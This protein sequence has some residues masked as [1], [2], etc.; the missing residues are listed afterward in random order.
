MPL[1]KSADW[2][3][4]TI[5]LAMLALLALLAVVGLDR[6]A[7]A[8]AKAEARQAGRNDAA[9]LV[10][11]LQAEL[12]KFSVAPLVLAGDPEVRALLVDGG[13]DARH[14]DRRFE[15]LA[16]Q[17]RAAAI[18]LMDRNGE[19]LA[20]SNWRLPSTFVGSNY[21]FRRYFTD[22][23]ATGSGTQFA[24]GTVSR[25]P[26][27][28]IAQ[29]VRAEGR[30]IGI[31]AVKVEFDE[32]ERSWR[33]AT[34]GVFVTDGSGVVL[35]ASNDAWRFH[36]T[37][38]D[39]AASRDHTLDNRQFGTE[40]LE[41]LELDTRSADRRTAV[42]L[43]DSNLPIALPGWRLHLLVDPGERISAARAGLRLYV[44]LAA[45]VLG[46]LLVTAVVLRNR[47]ERIA[48]RLVADR[49][50][51]LREQLGQANRLALLGQITAGV[52]HEINQPVAAARVY[53]E[54]GVRLLDRGRVDEAR[55]NFGRIVGIA[56]R[57]GAITDELRRFGRRGAAES[58]LMP[59]G[60]PIDGAILLLHDRILR[61]SV[62]LTLPEGDQRAIRVRAEPVRLEQVL[63]NLLQNALD[64]TPPGGSIA[65]S[66]KIEGAFCL[67]T[68]ADEGPGLGEIGD[69][70]FQPFATTK[71]GGLGLGLVISRD[72]MRDLG[73]DLTIGPSDGGARFIMR[74]PLG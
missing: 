64:A 67:L 2:R 60:Q 10:A 63:V 4:L 14:L 48:E 5:G 29:A 3:M 40:R 59:I 8:T 45:A 71:S 34:P 6:Q 37:R 53:A 74:I 27:L 56:E 28:Y 61:S 19:T 73:G 16:A 70:I 24:L 44:L 22:A 26:G 54:N 72:I 7:T 9:I 42:P 33:E 47:R 39:L 55:T 62:A 13:A 21:R 41:P 18:Y 17:T 68:V 65:L 31:V 52:G 51:S 50:H 35:L 58:G 66:I 57:I 38:P 46:A 12:D 20:A 25:K 30:T 11:G 15:A 43:I 1:P 36:T 23:I 49:T 69:R 32:L